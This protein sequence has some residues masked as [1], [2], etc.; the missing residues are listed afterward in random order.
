MSLVPD[1]VIIPESQQFVPNP[2]HP[3]SGIGCELYNTKKESYY[4]YTYNPQPYLDKLRSIGINDGV[5]SRFDNTVRTNCCNAISIMLYMNIEHCD[6]SKLILYLFCIYATVKNTEKNLPDW[7][8]RLYLDSSLYVCIKKI[9]DNLKKNIIHGDESEIYEIF[10]IIN[11]SKNVE[12]YMYNCFDNE[13]D[14]NFINK[15]YYRILRFLILTDPTVNMCAIREA[16][17]IL[18]NLECHNLNMFG[19]SDRLFY[20]PPFISGDLIKNDYTNIMMY[21]SYQYWTEVYKLVIQNNFFSNHL[22]VYELLAGLFTTKLKLKSDFYFSKSQE[23]YDTLDFIKNKS[24]EEIKARYIRP[25]NSNNPIFFSNNQFGNTFYNSIY[26]NLN[27]FI[28]SDFFNQMR[29]RLD[30]TFD[31]LLLLELYKEVISVS[32]NPEHKTP[33]GRFLIFNEEAKQKTSRLKELFYAHNIREFEI[34]DRLLTFDKLKTKL[35]TLGIIAPDF[36]LNESYSQ[37]KI[38]LD[39]GDDIYKIDAIFFKHIKIQEPINIFIN[40]TNLLAPLNVNWK[41]FLSRKKYN[42]IYGTQT[43][44]YREKYLKYKAKYLKLKYKY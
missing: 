23:L 4:T 38:N 25:E 3:T 42:E 11:N 26:D 21:D 32:F 33:N 16:D 18:T 7:I 35:I 44:G 2:V 37:I 10:N 40:R 22:N 43:G 12:I 1:K 9:E 17:G 28:D 30:F 24:I 8:I 20:L 36:Q 29:I 5:L 31:E 13:T 27:Q 14:S 6:Y 19:N 34:N 41:I 15:H 39:R